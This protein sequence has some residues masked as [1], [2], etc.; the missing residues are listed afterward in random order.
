MGPG[1]QASPPASGSLR[2]ATATA[3]VLDS[4]LSTARPSLWPAL[5]P[6]AGGPS[7]LDCPW[8]QPD[9]LA[10]AAAVPAVVLSCGLF[11][12]PRCPAA[13]HPSKHLI[14]LCLQAGRPPPAIP[15]H[16]SPCR[17]DADKLL[18]LC[19]P[20]PSHSSSHWA[21]SWQPSQL[22][23]ST[24][25]T[26]APQE[27]TSPVTVTC[28]LICARL[29]C[30]CLVSLCR[31]A[32]PLQACCAVW[33][34]TLP[35]RTHT[36]CLVSDGPSCCCSYGRRLLSVEDLQ[37]E[38]TP[39]F[40]RAGRSLLQSYGPSYYGYGGRC[41]FAVMPTA[42]LLPVMPRPCTPAAPVLPT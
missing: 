39:L 1:L 19:R 25:T 41:D 42:L 23:H 20:P 5:G 26:T 2:G 36:Q 24:A 10:W 22:W 34:S 9:R 29:V 3:R 6:A 35:S 12:E 15:D 7:C 33:L 31:Q 38:Q 14:S 13:A 8:A 21:C 11:L 17:A 30:V 32:Q 37:G 18:C 28:V 40:A 4:K 27:G 16:S